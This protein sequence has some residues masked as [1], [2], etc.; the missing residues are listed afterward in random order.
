[1]PI[2][3]VNGVQLFWEQ[4]GDHG[5]PLVLVHGSWG[6]HHNWDGVVPALARTFRVL[7]YDRRGHSQSERVTTQGSVEEDVAD[8]AAL[9]TSQ[10]LTPA[11][12]VGNS[13]GALIAL[14]LAAMHPDLF[15]SLTAHEPP[16]IGLLGNDPAVSVVQQRIGAVIE[17]LQSGETESGARQFVETVALGPG[18]WEKLPPEMRQ[19]FVFNAPTWL[20]EMNES[21]AFK[22]DLA[23][24]T[25]FTQPA[26]IT[27]GDQS[28]PFFG[29]IL[30]KIVEMLPHAQRHTFRRA[31]HVPHLTHPE[32]FVTVAA[33]FISSVATASSNLIWNDPLSSPDLS[34]AM[35]S[36]RQTLQTRPTGRE[37]GGRPR[38]LR[39][40]VTLIFGGYHGCPGQSTHD[41]ASSG[42]R[43]V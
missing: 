31:G 25:T 32:D 29:A 37:D 26:L 12:V 22:L 13:F 17:T 34:M 36:F 35:W 7:T 14:K 24:L 6:D 30:N 4:T 9:M 43:A 27:Q 33:S 20:D 41:S 19:T 2:S 8:L 10:H 42:G 18:M 5:V 40:R 21:S 39:R 11:H 16:L 1:M 3:R 15:A 23:R 28:P 38:A